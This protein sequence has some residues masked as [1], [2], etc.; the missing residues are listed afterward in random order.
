MKR[1]FKVLA[2]VVI[3]AFATSCA[4]ISRPVA[5]TTHPIGTKCGEA[6][7]LIFFGLW[8]KDGKENGIDKAAKQA[9]ITKISHVDAYTTNFFFGVVSKQTTKVYGE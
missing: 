8:S 3:C 7:S 5:A 6:K 1:A 4:T 9:G 2:A